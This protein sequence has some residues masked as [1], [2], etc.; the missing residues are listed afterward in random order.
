MNTIRPESEME[1]IL[2]KF[3]L[4]KI[5]DVKL[6]DFFSELNPSVRKRT[7]RHSVD[8]KIYQDG[9]SEGQKL[10]IRHGLGVQKSSDKVC[11]L[12]D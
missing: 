5:H 11:L 10:R 6:D 8:P 12:E 4:S 2:D 3:A 1:A 9:I 7:V